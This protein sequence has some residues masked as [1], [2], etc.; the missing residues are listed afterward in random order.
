MAL[1]S[2][3]LLG[4][5]RQAGRDEGQGPPCHSEGVWGKPSATHFPQHLGRQT[6][7]EQS[8]SAWAGTCPRAGQ[9]PDLGWAG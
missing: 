7:T 1:G 8:A 3:V 9:L 6:Q 4:A 5:G 2:E